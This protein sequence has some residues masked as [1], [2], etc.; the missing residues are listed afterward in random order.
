VDLFALLIDQNL[1]AALQVVE[2]AKSATSEVVELNGS[3]V[4]SLEPV[5][6]CALALAARIA[7]RMGEF[8]ELRAWRQTFAL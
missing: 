2:L 4:I 3:R 5:G 8:F 1:R 6:A 7:K